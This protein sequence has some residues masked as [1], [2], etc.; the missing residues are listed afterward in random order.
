[1]HLELYHRHYI[2]FGQNSF[3]AI[4]QQRSPAFIYNTKVVYI[5]SVIQGL[6]SGYGVYTCKTQ[7]MLYI[8]TLFEIVTVR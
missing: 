5:T 7:P 8:S 4:S 1:M 3:H 6:R 2:H